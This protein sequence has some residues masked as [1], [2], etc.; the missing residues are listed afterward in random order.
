[1]NNSSTF[2]QYCSE[3]TLEKPH[4]GILNFPIM[5]S[6]S[7]YHVAYQITNGIGYTFTENKFRA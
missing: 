4:E 7:S 5:L 3:V 6:S 1:M 2:H